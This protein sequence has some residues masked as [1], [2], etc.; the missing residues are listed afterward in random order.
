MEIAPV[1][2]LMVPG[3]HD[4]ITLF[5]LG[6]VIAA[7]YRSTDRTTIVNEATQRRYYRWGVTLL[8][9]THGDKAG[10]KLADLPLVM[11]QERP[12]DWNKS[13]FRIWRTGHLH[14]KHG[15]HWT[16]LNTMQG[17]E[18]T[19][20]PSLCAPDAWHTSKSLQYS[21][22]C[23]IAYAHDYELGPRASFTTNIIND[24]IASPKAA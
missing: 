11:A 12:D 5:T 21:T 4:R 14:T 20:A 13:L 17:V 18:C 3:N 2:V 9:Y 22:R 10:P 23:A 8:A 6:E 7:H 1:D 19:V 24:K 15:T 16:G